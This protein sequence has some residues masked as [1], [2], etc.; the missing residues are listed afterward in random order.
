VREYSED[1]TFQRSVGV[2]TSNK[3]GTLENIRTNCGAPVALTQIGECRYCKAVI[4]S[5]KFDWLLSRIEQEDQAQA[6][7]DRGGGSSV[8]A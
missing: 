8:A 4:T 3:P 1:W 5:G 6:G 2:A 7:D